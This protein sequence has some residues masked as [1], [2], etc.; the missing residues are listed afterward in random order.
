MRFGIGV[1]MCLILCTN[2]L[3]KTEFPLPVGPEITLLNDGPTAWNDRDRIRLERKM[4]KDCWFSKYNR[5]LLHYSAAAAAAV[6]Y[7]PLSGC[8]VY[9]SLSGGGVYPSLS[10]GGGGYA[11]LLCGYGWVVPCL[12]PLCLNMTSSLEHLSLHTGHVEDI[13]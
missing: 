3:T 7:I 13:S 6:A 12:F 5:V 4:C 9:P 10:G 2:L 11:P 1:I 8:G